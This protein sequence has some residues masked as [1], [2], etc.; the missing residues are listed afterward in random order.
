MAN[1][2]GG[3][4]SDDRGVAEEKYV[5]GAT[6]YAARVAAGWRELAQAQKGASKSAPAYS[7]YVNR[8]LGRLFAALAVPLG[9][10][11]NQIT[12]LSAFCTL[13]G[14]LLIAL[15]P[16]GVGVG[17]AVALL[18]VLGYAL[19]SSDG[20]VARLQRSGSMAG[21]WLDHCVDAVKT[22]AL[23]LAVAVG[24]YR[25]QIEPEWV[26]LVPLLACVIGA[27]T[28]FLMILTEQFR[29]RLGTKG[30]STE[31]GAKPS[32][33]RGLMVLP[34]DYGVMC[35]IFVLWGNPNIFLPVYA[36]ITLGAA[37]FLMLAMGKW[38]RE[39][40]ALVGAN[41]K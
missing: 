41:R 30:I 10:S 29:L 6:S 12:M 2:E 38:Y 36:L 4:F 40:S 15:A 24:L 23:P 16:A 33:M 17:I 22:S 11:P 27:S 1:F 5:P 28:F 20:Q 31:N 19:D 9:I 34:M 7:R 32:M 25:A 39:I 35:W 18:L 8:R 3:A 26:I 13:C 14:I 37:V 21:E